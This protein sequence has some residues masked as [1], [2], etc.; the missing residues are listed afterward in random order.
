MKKFVIFLLCFCFFM[1]TG[2]N[3]KVEEDFEIWR[4]EEEYPFYRSE[5]KT[6][7]EKYKEKNPDLTYRD[8]LLR[9]NIGL[10]YPYYSNVSPSKHLNTKNIL[11]NKYWYLSSDYVP[12]DLIELTNDYSKG[13]ISLVREAGDA[14]MRLVEAAANDHISIRAISA[15][16]S[17]QY[18]SD[19]YHRYVESDGVEKADTYS[20]RPGFSEHQT[21]LCVDVDNRVLPYTNFEETESFLWMQ[22]NAHKYGFILRFPKNKESIT[23]YT[24]ESWHYRYVGREVADY[25]KNHNITFD[26]YYMEF[27]EK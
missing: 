3:Q 23:G 16:R 9:V 6:R 27:L 1:I 13:G 10:D 22:D 2:C 11:V 24:Y 17:Y 20:A 7:Y 12:D 21:G 26:E 25:I 18:Q 19:L 5:Y 8:V 15:Y 14:F 4:I